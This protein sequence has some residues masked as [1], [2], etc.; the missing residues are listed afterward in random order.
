MSLR[1]SASEL[2]T[3][4]SAAAISVA[5]VTAITEID[6]TAT[7]PADENVQT[8]LRLSA[9]ELA[10]LDGLTFTQM[11]VRF[12][13]SAAVPQDDYPALRRRTKQPAGPNATTPRLEYL[14]PSK[15]KR[16]DDSEELTE[17]EIQGT[18][19]GSGPDPLR[20][21][22]KSEDLETEFQKKPANPMKPIRSEHYDY[23][24]E[25]HGIMYITR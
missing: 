6:G 24:I 13:V 3:V 8:E 4:L 21:R 7:L 11:Y 20:P 22:P 14:I 19:A 15:P 23:G 2:L 10:D 25:N 12:R 17:E 9:E 5:P 18:S 1:S 16:E